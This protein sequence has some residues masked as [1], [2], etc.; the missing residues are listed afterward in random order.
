MLTDPGTVRLL[1]RFLFL[2]LTNRVRELLGDLAADA[3]VQSLG[4]TR[5]R[6]AG[7]WQSR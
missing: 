5:S 4:T 1:A 2:T 6:T 7:R 3:S